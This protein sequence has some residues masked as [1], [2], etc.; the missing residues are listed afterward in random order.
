MSAFFVYMRN[1]FTKFLK[2][3]KSYIFENAQITNQ[4]FYS[5]H[6]N[7]SPRLGIQAYKRHPVIYW[8]Y[9][10]GIDGFLYRKVLVY[11]SY[12]KMGCHSKFAILLCY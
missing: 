3:R 6:N 4:L 11:Q 7:Y 1:R 10:M 9:I 2:P 12:N 8:R 5:H